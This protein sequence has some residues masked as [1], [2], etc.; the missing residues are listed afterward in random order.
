MGAAERSCSFHHQLLVSIKEGS[1]FCLGEA[2]LCLR[3][4]PRSLSQ[5]FPNWGKKGTEKHL[6]SS[7]GLP[8]TTLK[9]S[10]G[11]LH[12]ILKQHREC[13]ECPHFIDKK[14]QMNAANTYWSFSICWVLNY[15]I[16]Y[17]ISIFKIFYLCYIGIYL[18]Y[19]H[20]EIEVKKPGD[21]V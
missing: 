13:C 2:M 1:A 4:L 10:Y 18:Y 3:N 6:L 9:S 17:V 21:L 12:W 20:K 19:T 8:S 14:N 7:Y 16:P 15:A 11:L 5:F